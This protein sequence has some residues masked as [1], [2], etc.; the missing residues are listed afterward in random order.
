M[1]TKTLCPMRN[2]FCAH[3]RLI[4]AV[5][6]GGGTCERYAAGRQWAE[7]AAALAQRP[8]VAPVDIALPRTD[9]LTASA[10]LREQCPG[11]RVLTLIVPGQPGNP[12]S[13]RP[14]RNRARPVILPRQAGR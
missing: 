1:I 5:L 14:A 3:T 9:G 4:G 10:A 8:Y 2:L 11:C 12:L 7:G 6:P 13:P